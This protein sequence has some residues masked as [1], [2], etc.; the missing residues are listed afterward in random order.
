MD[1]YT[2]YYLR[3]AKSGFSGSQYRQQSGRGLGRF[4]MSIIRSVSPWMKSGFRA[5]GN[6]LLSTGAGILTDTVK[7]V[8]T[9]ESF[10]NR[11]REL[12]NN[13]TERAVNKVGSMTGGGR[14]VYKRKATSKCHLSVKRKR[15]SKVKKTAVKKTKVKKKKVATKSKVKRLTKRKKR[16]VSAKTQKFLDIF[17]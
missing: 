5:L 14:R 12:G 8:P 9:N 16:T 11:I 1:P 6:E 4:L 7:Q 2:A 15:R 10:K 13:L 3:Q 17:K